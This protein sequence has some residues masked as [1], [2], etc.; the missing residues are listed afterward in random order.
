M[1]GGREVG[2]GEPRELAVFDYE[3]G[4]E[5]GDTQNKRGGYR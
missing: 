5:P 2:E 1:V 4:W 3:F